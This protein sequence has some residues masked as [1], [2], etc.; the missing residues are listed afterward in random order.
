MDAEP[1]FQVHPATREQI[2]S[3]GLQ[4]QVGALPQDTPIAYYRVQVDEAAEWM[5]LAILPTGALL[6][7]G[8]DPAFL[9]GA[10]SPEEALAMFFADDEDE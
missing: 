9:E 1:R 6:A 4:T 8:A 3:H 10:S 7:W 2:T 5:E